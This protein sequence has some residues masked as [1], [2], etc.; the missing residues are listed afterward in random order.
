VYATITSI[1]TILLYLSYV[2]PLFLAARALGRT[3]TELGPFQLGIWFKPAAMV[4]VAGCAG[5][6]AIGVQPPNEQALVV[7]GALMVVL[8]ACWFMVAAQTFKGPPTIGAADATQLLRI[9]ES[10][11]SM[12]G[13]GSTP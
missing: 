1:C 11:V 8:I 10:E 4:S 7:L 12:D 6:V 9:H 2:V 13:E 3:W 5:L